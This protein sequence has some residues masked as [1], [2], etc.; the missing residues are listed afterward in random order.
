VALLVF[1]G[2]VVAVFFQ[3]AHLAGALDLLRNFDAAARREIEMF[4]PQTF[5]GAARETM[6]RH[7]VRLSIDS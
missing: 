5:E 3:V 6:R 1:G 7:G 4:S 2:V